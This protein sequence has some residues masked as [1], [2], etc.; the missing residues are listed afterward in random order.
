MRLLIMPPSLLLLMVFQISASAQDAASDAK[1]LAELTQLEKNSWEAMMN[2]DKEFFRTYMAPEAKCFPADGSIIGRDDVIRNLDD[3]HLTKYSMAEVSLLRINEDSAMVTYRASYE[4]VHKNK[5]EQFS[6]VESSSLYVRREGKWLEIFYQETA[7]PRA[8][9]GTAEEAK[10]LVA[11]GIALI[12]K[13]GAAA[14][15]KINA[16]EDGLKD[17]D[18]YLFVHNTE[19]QPKVVAYGGPKLKHDPIGTPVT[20]IVGFGG[21][22]IG[23]LVQEQ[24]TEKG[25]WIDYLWLNPTTG[26]PEQK[27]TWFV[28]SGGYVVGCG[29][30]GSAH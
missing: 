14:F 19:A 27:F 25:A 7:K 18:L 6:D 20:E 3:Y 24:A 5:K 8:E 17:R 30:Y 9:H 23:K 1:L 11:K 13:E 16:G 21:K 29:I 2:D 22:Q 28:R 15:P 26:K 12:A 4:G 10:A